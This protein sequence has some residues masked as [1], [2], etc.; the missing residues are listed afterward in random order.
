MSDLAPVDE[1]RSL[2]Y[3]L[4]LAALRRLEKE[5]G[6]EA[7]AALR[8]DPLFWARPAQLIKD[9]D[10][11][12]TIEVFVGER[13]TGKTWA[14]RHL[15]VELVRTGRARLPR[16]VSST[17]AAI[18]E[19]V[20]DGESGIKTWLPPPREGKYA[21]FKSDGFAGTLHLYGT[22]IVCCSAAAPGQAIGMSRDVTWADDPAGW[23][24]SC[25]VDTATE[26]WTQI[27]KSNSQGQSTV[28]VA[29]T[30]AGAAF[31]SDLLSPEQLND[32]SFIRIHDLGAVESN[33]G[34]LAPNYIKHTV[35]DLRRKLQWNDVPHVS[36][37]APVAFERMRLAR[38]PA[39]VEIAVAIDPEPSP[40][41]FGTA[42]EKP[43]RL[44]GGKGR[45]KLRQGPR[46]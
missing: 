22:K 10:N 34:N 45:V 36:P 35:A 20:L 42:E 11:L 30:A 38:C 7:V 41:T 44:A 3:P 6:P 31:L 46:I 15:F 29:T 17:D 33:R 18:V 32:P 9:L 25:G 37:W 13:R 5:A 19:V 43:A 39:L 21:W 4:I 26:A 8:Y 16:I 12:A 27:L 40:R 2:P 1:L 23:V 24:E 28:I 14:A